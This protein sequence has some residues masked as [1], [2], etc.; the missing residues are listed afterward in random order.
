M[1]IKNK[2][3]TAVTTAGLLAGLFGS[4]FVPAVK[5]AAGDGFSSV[6]ATP[7]LEVIEQP[8]FSSTGITNKGE[9][10]HSADVANTAVLTAV[11]GT[12]TDNL[13]T[14][15]AT[16]LDTVYADTSTT[17][18]TAG[19]GFALSYTSATDRVMLF[20]TPTEAVSTSS[21]L[22]Y[23]VAS[24]GAYA[25]AAQS[26]TPVARVSGADVIGTN[27]GSQVAATGNYVTITLG[28]GLAV[29]S[30]SVLD[31]AVTSGT[32]PTAGLVPGTATLS[33]TD[34]TNLQVPA[35]AA[36]ELN[37]AGTASSFRVTYAGI[38]TSTITISGV[39]DASGVLTRATL[40]TI[41]ITWRL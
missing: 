25:F 13:L 18:R 23:T 3:V 27:A 31:I 16:A 21:T 8:W 7:I 28:D 37:G 38:S 33:R 4:A 36:T 22:T 24:A 20:Y 17:V 30:T 15:S 5:A 14:G 40:Q 32:V 29:G 39:K 9:V 12:I 1:S 41:T 11:G 10:A 6:P 2:L 26:A 19:A 34:S 35:S